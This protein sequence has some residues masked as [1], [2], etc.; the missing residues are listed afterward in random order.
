MALYYAID[1]VH[2]FSRQLGDPVGH[3][4]NRALMTGNPDGI[5]RCGLGV[6]SLARLN[7]DLH[8]RLAR[9]LS[10]SLPEASF[11]CPYSR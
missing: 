10:R 2:L 4:G 5:A 9:Q 6:D 1:Q 3:I 7:R 8:Q 11:A